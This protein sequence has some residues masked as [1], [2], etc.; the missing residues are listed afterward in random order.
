MLSLKRENEIAGTVRSIGVL[1]F[2]T[3]LYCSMLCFIKRLRN[4][5]REFLFF[6]FGRSFVMS[7][8]HSTSHLIRVDSEYRLESYRSPHAATFFYSARFIFS[9]ACDKRRY[10]ATVS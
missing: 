8:A 7:Y 4:K 10:I 6:P 3:E 9:S 2:T 1:E 5:K